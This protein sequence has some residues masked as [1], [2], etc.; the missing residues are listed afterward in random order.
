MCERFIFRRRWED[1]GVTSFFGVT[2]TSDPRQRNDRES[3]I[4]V[5]V[6]DT[7][8]LRVLLF[9][10]VGLIDSGR[11]IADRPTHARKGTF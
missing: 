3:L 6:V 11:E 1:G 8:G 2:L 4:W 10:F 9:C 5:R 7:V